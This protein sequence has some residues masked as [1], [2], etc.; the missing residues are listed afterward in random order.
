MKTNLTNEQLETLYTG[1]ENLADAVKVGKGSVS[2]EKLDAIFEYIGIEKND[3]IVREAN[4]CIRMLIDIFNNQGAG[5]QASV[6]KITSS[7]IPLKLAS[8]IVDILLETKSPTLMEQREKASKYYITKAGRFLLDMTIDD[9]LQAHKLLKRFEKGNSLG[10]NELEYLLKNYLLE[11]YVPVKQQSEYY[12]TNAGK[13]LLDMTIDELQKAREL[14]RRFDLKN[15]L[16]KKELEYLLNND[17][18]D[19]LYDQTV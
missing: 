3:E 17:F 1:L 14:S 2:N 6:A 8:A 4:N 13:F 16:G 12:I 11:K 9:L 5:R 7:G 18:L 10:K 19:E 15:S